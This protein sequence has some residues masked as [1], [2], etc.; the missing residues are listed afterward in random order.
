[1]VEQ[2][3]RAPVIRHAGEGEKRWFFGGGAFTIKALAAD[4]DGAFFLFEDVMEKGKVTPLH[5]HPT[6]ES[7][8]VLEGEML[9][10]FEH[11]QIRLG[12]GAFA[13][14][15]RGVP[16]AFMV[17][18]DTCRVLCLQAPGQCEGFY[19]GASEPLEGSSREVDFGRIGTS[20]QENG[21]ITLLGPPP[22]NRP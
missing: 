21:G 13:L 12:K 22:F 20:A 4:T 18:S 10:H 7:W 17:L 5:T 15:P 1:M 3:V 9:L 14:A 19:L 2:L 11:E 16:H 6:D 8:Y